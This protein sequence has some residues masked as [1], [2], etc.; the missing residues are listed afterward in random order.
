M[1]ELEFGLLE[2]APG[3]G[4]V[5]DQAPQVDQRRRPVPLVVQPL[6]EIV[7]ADQAADLPLRAAAR[8]DVS[9]LLARDDQDG[10]GIAQVREQF[11]RL[12]APLPFEGSPWNRPVPVTRLEELVGLDD[13]HP[14]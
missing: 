7:A 10:C 4:R 11:L 13:E 3:A 9:E 8:L 2:T 6:D 14:T 1:I 12:R 5:L